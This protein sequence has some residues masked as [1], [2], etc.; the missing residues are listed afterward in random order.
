M[1]L[2]YSDS[3]SEDEDVSDSDDDDYLNREQLRDYLYIKEGVVSD[4][5]GDYVGDTDSDEYNLESATDS[6]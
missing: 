5:E 1:S 4:I 3:E 2:N 6:D